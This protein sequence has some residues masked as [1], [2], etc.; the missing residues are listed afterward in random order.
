[1]YV[2]A[3]GQME[4]GIHS[5]NNCLRVCVYVCLCESGH[6]SPGGQS[7]P[8]VNQEAGGTASEREKRKSLLSAARSPACG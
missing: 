4:R 7:R 5:C 2:C 6:S 3:E 1:M 8:A